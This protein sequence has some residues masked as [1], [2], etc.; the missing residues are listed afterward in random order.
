MPSSAWRLEFRRVLDRKSTRL[1]SSHPT[2]SY[3]VFCLKKNNQ[4]A[5]LGQRLL[6]CDAL[7]V[8]DPRVTRLM[9]LPLPRVSPLNN[10]RADKKPSLFCFFLMIRRPPRSTLFPYPALFRSHHDDVPGALFFGYRALRHPAHQG[11]DRSEEHTSELQ[12]PNNLVCRL[13]L[14]RH[15]AA[16]PRGQARGAHRAPRVLL[17]AAHPRVQT[18]PRPSTPARA[19]AARGSPATCLLFFYRAAAPRARPPSPPPPFPS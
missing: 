10:S 3:A 4:R 18:L 2:I 14:E 8:A 17:R 6:A 1:N 5:T 13:L 15:N 16:R 9:R 12:S 11:D 7:R 19:S